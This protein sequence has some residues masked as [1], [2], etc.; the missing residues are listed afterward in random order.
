MGDLLGAVGIPTALRSTSR[1]QMAHDV[2]GDPG[3]LQQHLGFVARAYEKALNEEPASVQDRWHAHLYFVK[4]AAHLMLAAFW[5]AT[6]IVCLTTGRDEAMTLARSAGLGGLDGI[7]TIFGGLFDIVIGVAL[8]IFA[9]FK[10]AILFLMAAVTIIYIAVLT[11]S[12]PYLWTDPLGRLMKL[13]PF[14]ALLA[15]LAVVEDER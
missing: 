8:L 15:F 3:A 1:A 11:Y 5:I 12:L 2:G 9:R 7:T 4:P 6:G 10:R 13:I 14:F